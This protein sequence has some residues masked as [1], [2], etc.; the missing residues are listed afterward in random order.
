MANTREV[1][2]A[3]LDV[4]PE[5]KLQIDFETRNEYETV[6]T[7]L[8]KLWAERKQILLAVGNDDEPAVHWSLCASWDSGACA[9]TFHLGKARI[10][11]PKSYSFTIVAKE[12]GQ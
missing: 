12:D 7:K 8:V 9:G 11:Q 3:L 5:T 6:R 10:R 4:E 1:F 2:E